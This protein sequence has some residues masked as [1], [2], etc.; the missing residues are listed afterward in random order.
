[1]QTA[2]PY[3]SSMKC[4][5]LTLVILIT[6]SGCNGATG[7][8][9]ATM[10]VS[11]FHDN[12]NSED[13]Q[14]LYESAAEEVHQGIEREQFLQVTQTIRRKLGAVRSSEVAGWRTTMRVGR[15][16]VSLSLDVEYENGS[17]TED[18][19]WIIT[20]NDASWTKY[21][22]SSPLLMIAE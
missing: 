13:Y 3:L 17:G 10:A 22:V 2:E 21:N 15:K 1:M 5:A 8:E 14:A 7:V 18:Y 9:E 16:E 19:V 11:A 6:L 20:D 4:P 12:Y